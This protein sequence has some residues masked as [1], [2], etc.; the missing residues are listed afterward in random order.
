MSVIA[1]MVVDEI[2]LQRGSEWP[3]EHYE[4]DHW[5][6]N[7]AEGRDQTACPCETTE[8]IGKTEVIF[9]AVYDLEPGHENH[10]FWQATPSADF[11]MQIENRAAAEYFKVGEEHYVEIRKAQPNKAR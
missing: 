5:F 1:K 4:E 10:M 8:G 3:P 9:K 11:S 7:M 2:V 6:T